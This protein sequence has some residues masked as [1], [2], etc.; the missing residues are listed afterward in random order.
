MTTLAREA[1]GRPATGSTLEPALKDAPPNPRDWNVI[2][3]SSAGTIFEWYD[4]FLAGSLAA[5]LADAFMPG[6]D[7]DARFALVLVGFAIGFAVRPLGAL[8][9][10]RLGDRVGRKRSFLL[11][12][13]VMGL[14]TI[15]MGLLPG[16]AT[17]GPA[18][19]A[20][21]IVCR[22]LQG[23]ALG[24]EYGGAI[25][26]VAEH[27]PPGR[28]G[29][30]TS[31]IQTNATLGLFLSLAVVLWLRLVLSP[32]AFA[33]WG[34]RVP[35][36]LS[37]LLLL[38][39]VWIRLRLGET[40]VFQ[41]MEAEGAIAR[42]PL[43]EA[44]GRWTN[45]KRALLA[46][47]AT[48]GQAVVWYTGQFYALFFLTQVLGVASATADLLM[49]L[50]LFAGMPFFLLF[51]WLSDRIGRKPVLL[52]GLAAA[53]LAYFPLF[54]QL[55]HLA[56]PKLDAAIQKTKVVV[57]ADPATC[58][59]LFDPSG[60]HAFSTPCDV[61][62]RALAAQPI[63]YELAAAPPGAPL[64]ATVNGR[65]VPDPTAAAV[66]AAAQAAGYPRADDPT[67]LHAP[68]LG[69][70]L[71]D[72]R[73]RQ[74]WAV[75]FA[76]V[77]LVTAVYGPIAALLAELFPTRIRYTGVSLPYHVGNGWFGGFLPPVSFAAIAATGN[78][79]S[80]LWYP[81][82]VAALAFVLGWACLPETADRD[83]H[84]VE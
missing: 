3:A 34:W 84:A 38:V 42:A 62:R 73:A 74:A 56:N 33:A 69:A 28:R 22:L 6:A 24:G 43:R 8:V 20:L 44:F 16:Y 52:V 50:A 78:I 27:A 10:G 77:V 46:L 58:G 75:L 5:H 39:S 59:H 54:A 47:C 21:F 35:F 40:P 72:P 7:G 1:A 29:L 83:L 23:L 11:T 57:S 71:R 67:I 68:T 82:L 12:I 2:L 76:L 14:A 41:R 48:M 80:G 30:H 61:V 49:A 51:G 60:V 17:I 53:A 9:F 65:P 64:A 31:F 25:T 26:Y 66:V 81:V 70:V 19:P 63:R 55:A 18:A 36:L 79:L 15:A 45:I 32:E 13:V 37:A 4:F